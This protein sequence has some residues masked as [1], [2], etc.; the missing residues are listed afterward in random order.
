MVNPS[1]D[2]NGGPKGKVNRLELCAPG[3]RIEGP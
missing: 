2:D 3:R 1:G